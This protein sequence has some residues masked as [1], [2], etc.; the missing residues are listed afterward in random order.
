MG[1]S[2]LRLW[3]NDKESKKAGAEPLR[4][5]VLSISF[6]ISISTAAAARLV[7]GIFCAWAWAVGTFGRRGRE[8]LRGRVPW[9]GVLPP[10]LQALAAGCEFV[11]PEGGVEK[12]ATV[13]L[14]AGASEE[15][16]TRPSL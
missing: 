13:L 10:R 12:K 3:K 11:V 9:P 2:R 14:L 8:C 7:G 1:G 5:Q 4:S 6:S 16:H 15:V